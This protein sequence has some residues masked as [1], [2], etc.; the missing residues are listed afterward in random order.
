MKALPEHLY[1][2]LSI[3]Q[4]GITDREEG[5]SNREFIRKPAELLIRWEGEN[6]RKKAGY[7]NAQITN[8]GA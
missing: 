4:S 8:Q 7:Q 5:P 3:S 1:F 6:Y 2:S